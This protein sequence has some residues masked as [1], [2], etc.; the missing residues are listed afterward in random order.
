MSANVAIKLL[1]CWRGQVKPEYYPRPLSKGRESSTGKRK[2]T[3]LCFSQRICRH[4]TCV[5]GFNFLLH[6]SQWLDSTDLLDTG[7]S[8]YNQPPE[9]YQPWLLFSC[10]RRIFWSGSF[11]LIFPHEGRRFDICST[12]SRLEEQKQHWIFKSTIEKLPAPGPWKRGF[13]TWYN[14]QKSMQFCNKCSVLFVIK[15]TDPRCALVRTC[16]TDM[17][18]L[19]SQQRSNVINTSFTLENA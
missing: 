10:F 2:A 1:A 7:C 16:S 13:F 11:A 5:A 9:Q 18:G 4:L 17:L 19:P 8:K 12:R 3:L 15:T 14:H 6:S